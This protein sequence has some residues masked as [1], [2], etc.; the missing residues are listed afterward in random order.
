MILK[1]KILML[2]IFAIIVT[3]AYSTPLIVICL[4]LI[5]LIVLLREY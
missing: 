1:E 2:E 4:L 3:H 5:K